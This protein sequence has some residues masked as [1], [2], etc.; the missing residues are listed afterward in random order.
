M[1]LN[2]IEEIL[3]NVWDEKSIERKIEIIED[4]K[5]ERRKMVRNWKEKN[6]KERIDKRKIVNNVK[7][8]GI[9]K[10]I[11]GEEKGM[12]IENESGEVE[13]LKEGFRIIRNGYDRI[14]KGEIK[15]GLNFK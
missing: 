15:K 3:K 5:E 13:E 10:L 11:E 8:I 6:K 14:I 2:L 12:R 1:N 9:E 4:W 7:R